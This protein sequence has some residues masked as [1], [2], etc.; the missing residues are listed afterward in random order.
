MH[1]AG[2]L[3]LGAPAFRF[4]V[5]RYPIL[6]VLLDWGTILLLRTCMAAVRPLLMVTVTTTVAA[7]VARARGFSQLLL[8]EPF[9]LA[10]LLIDPPG[11]FKALLCACTYVQAHSSRV[12]LCGR[13]LAP[14]SPISSR[15]GL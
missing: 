3:S 5:S 9:F 10:I 14:T 11:R 6:N 1:R 8:S 13:P 4:C 7:T 2:G 12:I 15:A